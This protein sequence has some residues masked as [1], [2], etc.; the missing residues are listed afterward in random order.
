M[1]DNRPIISEIYAE[2]GAQWAEAD[3]HAT[4]LEDTKSSFLS[5][6]IQDI[7]TNDP[8]CPINRA[9]AQIKASKAW[10]NRI[11]ETVDARKK[12]NH[13]KVKMDSIR[14]AYGEWSSEE[15]NERTRARL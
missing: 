3:A 15:A 6:A 11:Y 4:I 7:L 8:K 1:G 2:I 13:L 14:M 10:V 12:A 5:Q 9:E